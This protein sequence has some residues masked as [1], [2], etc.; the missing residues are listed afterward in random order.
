MESRRT[1]ERRK[2]A[3]RFRKR[4]EVRYGPRT[5]EHTGYSGN[6]SRTGIMIRTTRVYGPGTTMYMEL[7]FSKQ[8]I[9]VSGLVTWA[10]EGSVQLLSTGRIGMGLKFIDPPQELMAL[11]DA[12][13]LDQSAP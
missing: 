10:R 7:I 4:I 13:G 8:T 2:A 5:P 9:R 1:G 6:I 3:M 11:V 12:R